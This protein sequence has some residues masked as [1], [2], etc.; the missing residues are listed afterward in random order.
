M[1]P[2]VIVPARALKVPSGFRGDKAMVKLLKPLTAAPARGEPGEGLAA[3][4]DP[5][6]FFSR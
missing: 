2:L 4:L 6:S 1:L 5:G 3:R